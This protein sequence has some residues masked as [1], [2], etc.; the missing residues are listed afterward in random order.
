MRIKLICV[1]LLLS[2]A[3]AQSSR[4][5]TKDASTLGSFLQFL[6]NE[7]PEESQENLCSQNPEGV[8]EFPKDEKY[9]H[10]YDEW[11][12][13]IAH[14]QKEDGTYL[15]GQWA[16]V[17]H[18]ITET[19]RM[20]YSFILFTDKMRYITRLKSQEIE[21]V[22]GEFSLDY[23]DAKAF[24]K[25]EKYQVYGE[26]DDISLSIN[27]TPLKAPFLYYGNGR[28]NFQYGG[29]MDYYSRPRNEIN[30]TLTVAG[31]EF[32]VSGYGYYERAIGRLRGVWRDGWDWMNI[33][34][35]DG[36][37]I[38]VALI[39]L[40]YYLWT[41][42]Q[43]CVKTQHDFKIEITST[44]LSHKT[45]CQYANGWKITFDDKEYNVKVLFDD[46]EVIEKPATKYEGPLVVSGSQ[47]GR[48]YIE[49]VGTC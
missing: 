10:M 5:E 17:K 20:E 1:S 34:L 18:H 27:V 2:L 35:D 37:E 21:E 14:L 36:T 29:Y 9:H 33:Q 45:E 49:T 26:V 41:Y 32:P 25:D 12:Y 16:F 6:D 30:G 28:L 4:L 8:I 46:S 19:P 40:N 22:D 24:G 31:E 13:W 23:G 42:D 43:N 7:T 39:R 38:L 44:W 48:G 11:W 3:L 47:T 15:S